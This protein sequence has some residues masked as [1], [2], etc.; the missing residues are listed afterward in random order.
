MSLRVRESVDIG[1]APGEGHMKNLELGAF[2]DVWRGYGPP[3]ASTGCCV[4]LDIDLS[5]L[6]GSP[7][8]CAE[9]L[10][11][12]N[13][14][15]WRRARCRGK[16]VSAFVCSQPHCA[17]RCAG[18]E[19]ATK[20]DGTGGTER[21]PAV[22]EAPPPRLEVSPV[23]ALEAEA[24]Y[25]GASSGGAGAWRQRRRA[26]AQAVPARPPEL[27][28]SSVPRC[29]CH[30]AV[31]RSAPRARQPSSQLGG[32]TDRIR[33][34]GARS[35]AAERSCRSSFAFYILRA[36]TGSAPTARPSA[37]IPSRSAR[38]EPCH[39]GVQPRERRRYA[40]SLHFTL[41]GPARL[42]TR[43]F[44]HARASTTRATSF[45]SANPPLSAASAM[46]WPPPFGYLF[47]R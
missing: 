15:W 44:V 40:E 23:A 6:R 26:Q 4:P 13:S 20:G 5:R 1:F 43:R 31:G 18:R 9:R 45:S 36:T 38:V 25:G 41:L 11:C 33:R 46:T 32:Q 22:A 16:S 17:R 37:S 39:Y 34:A 7:K 3:S 30:S 8:P 28:T 12:E 19:S 27:A 24:Q 10:S 14:S 47:L 21:I 35:K 2:C 29:P 42:R